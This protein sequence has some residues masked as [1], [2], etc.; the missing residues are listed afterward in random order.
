MAQQSGRILK[1]HAGLDDRL[2]DL[3]NIGWAGLRGFEPL[4]PKA[5]KWPVADHDLL[6]RWRETGQLNEQATFVAEHD[7]G[8]LA[9]V[10]SGSPGA[11]QQGTFHFF[12]VNAH[13]GGHGYGSRLLRAME[14]ALREAGMKRIVTGPI[15]SRCPHRNRFLQLKGYSVPDPERENIIML[16]QPA[17]RVVREVIL[18]DDTYRIETWRDE[19]LDDWVEVKNAVFEH[20]SERS[21]FLDQFRN[22]HDF[23]P[24]GW[25]FLRHGDRFIGITG[26]M[27]CRETDGRVRGGVIEW[28]GVRPEYRGKKLGEALVIAGLNYFIERDIAPVTLITQPFRKP[29]VALYE[30][31]GFTTAAAIPRYQKELDG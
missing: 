8:N 20:T 25:M 12:C 13:Y 23:D 4:Y 7:D 2:I 6:A 19:Y 24:E 14:E 28:V 1:Y 21:L 5:D 11:D 27:V 29:A 10:F 9:G 15:D 3:I 26:A 16:L 17:G 30:K 31:L 18:P 22:R